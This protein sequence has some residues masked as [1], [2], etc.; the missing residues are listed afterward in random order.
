MIVNV[1]YCETFHQ[2]KHF[3]KTVSCI[4]NKEWIS[5][6]F[7]NDMGLADPLDK[8]AKSANICLKF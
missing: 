2:S 4:V 8:I 5:F 6:S 1:L 3:Q 7:Y